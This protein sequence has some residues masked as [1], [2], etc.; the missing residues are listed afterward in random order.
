MLLQIPNKKTNQIRPSMFLNDIDLNTVLLSPKINPSDLEKSPLITQLKQLKKRQVTKLPLIR[1][2]SNISLSN[3]ESLENTLFNDAMGYSQ[4]MKVT[5]QSGEQLKLPQIQYS[6][7][8]TDPKHK[9]NLTEGNLVKK[10]VE[11]RASILVIDFI[12][13]VTRKDKIDGS[14]KPLIRKAQQRQQTKFLP[15]L[16]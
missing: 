2:K 9:K 4:S 5:I 3:K 13:Q 11:F 6:S 14:A 12:N 16:G 10:R 7:P 15:K 1:E 8:Q